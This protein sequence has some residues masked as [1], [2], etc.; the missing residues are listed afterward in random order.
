MG[1][2][3][4]VPGPTASDCC[5]GTEE[6]QSYGSP[7]D[8]TIPQCIG[9]IFCFA[10]HVRIISRKSPVSSPHLCL[11]EHLICGKANTVDQEIFV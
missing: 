5:V 10:K 1:D 4:A 8:C 6:G 11:H 2:I 7:K 9:I 3:V